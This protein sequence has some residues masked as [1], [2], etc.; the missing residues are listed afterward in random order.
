MAGAVS[1]SSC[2]VVVDTLVEDEAATLQ[3][4]VDESYDLSVSAEGACRLSAATVWG[5]LHGMETFSQLLSRP[6]EGQVA[7][8]FL[9]VAI[10]DSARFSHRGLLIDS[11]RHF[12]PVE[13][14]LHLVDSLPMSKFNVLHCEFSSTLTDFCLCV[15]HPHGMMSDMG[16]RGSAMA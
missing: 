11:S 7:L 6:A 13:E 5:A 4:G 8:D 9:P 14:L 10:T 12:L 16:L 15:N 3:L 1:I 2:Q